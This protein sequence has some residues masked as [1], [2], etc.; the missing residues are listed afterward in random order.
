MIALAMFDIIFPRVQRIINGVELRRYAMVPGVDMFNHDNK[1]A[2]DA[3]VE[4][5]YFTDSFD[6]LSGSDYKVGDQAFISYGEQSN[7]AFL[8]Y[9]GFVEE[10][11][12]ADTF[13]FD[14]DIANQVGIG[15]SGL[16]ARVGGFDAAVLKGV[17]KRV[18]GDRDKA[19]T[20][21]RETCRAQLDRFASTIE[22][23]AKLLKNETGTAEQ[24][25]RLSKA[26]QYRR[27]KKIL[28]RTIIDYW[29]GTV[30]RP[31]R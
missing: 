16:V 17:Q 3:Q 25:Q 22:E 26:I 24:W 9:Y 20:V 19:V 8:Q 13:I 27:E 28:L 11:N 4:F 15:S 31:R 2:R 30:V 1:T 18:G 6:V 29:D 10:S 23:D 14:D 7:D 21:L 5:R 12:P